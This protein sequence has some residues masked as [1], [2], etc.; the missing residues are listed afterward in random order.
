V[1]GS[2]LELRRA[3]LAV[4]GCYARR[5]ALDALD[6][7]ALSALQIRVAPDELLLIARPGEHAADTEVATAHLAHLD[8]GSFLFDVSDGYSVWTLTGEGRYEAFARLCPSPPANPPACVQGLFA[9]VP[10]KIVFGEDDLHVLV[11]S[12]L[13]HYLRERILIACADLDPRETKAA[14]LAIPPGERAA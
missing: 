10:A 4:I 2:V 6:A 9:H 3:Q 5:D 1:S 7:L 13:G 12:V 8:P 11:S 14:P